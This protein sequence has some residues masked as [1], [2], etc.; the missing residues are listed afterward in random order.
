MNIRIIKIDNSETA[1]EYL[2][3]QNSPINSTSKNESRNYT[4]LKQSVI[5]DFNYTAQ[6]DASQ[7]DKIEEI[8][9]EIS[10]S[11]YQKVSGSA[12]G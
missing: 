5:S 10:R 7:D 11:N 9:A 4:V 1:Q 8:S 2:G 6:I 12:V 3:T